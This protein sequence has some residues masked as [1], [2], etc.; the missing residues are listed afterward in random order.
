VDGDGNPDLLITGRDENDDQTATLYLGNGEGG[1]AESGAGLTGVSGSSTSIADVDG[2]GHSDLLI[3]GNAGTFSNSDPTATLYLGDGEGG[4]TE[5]G[6][7]LTGAQVSSTSIADVDGDEAPDVLVTGFSGTSLSLSSILYEN[8]FD[9]PLPVEMA[10]FEA[11]ADEDKVRLTWTT[12]SETGNA[13]FRVQRRVVEENG[14]GAWEQ[15]GEVEGAGTTTE[16]TS[17]RFRDTDLPYRADRL[18]YRLKQ[19]DTD[20]SASYTD[21]VSVERGV[22]EVEL[23]KTFPNPARGQA[24]VQFAVPERQEVTLQLYDLLGREVRTI[25]QGNVQGRQEL[26]VDLSGLASGTYFVRLSAGGRTLT[27]K[28]TVLK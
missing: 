3:T 7:G 21:P 19:V 25:Q 20:G 5:A 28:I 8:L 17:Y 13:G 23:R 14:E 1:F 4:F 15:V 2:D 24:T 10:G 27:Q 11:T 26:R 12:A 22:G 9:D 16:A 18:E 6:A